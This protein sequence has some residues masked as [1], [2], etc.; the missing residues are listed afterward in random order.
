M[1]ELLAVDRDEWTAEVALIAEYYAMFGERLPAALT[2]Q[3]DDLS[4]R[5]GPA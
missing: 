5:L 3:L 2:G 1:A 4:R